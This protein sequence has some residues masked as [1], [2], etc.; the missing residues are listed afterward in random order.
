MSSED[1][2]A[3]VRRSEFAAYLGATGFTGAAFAMQQL[4]VSW[5]LIGVLQLPADR[6]GL[7]Q[8]AIGLPGIVLMLWGGASADR[9]D[10]RSLLL[11]AYGLA[12]L[13]PAFLGL[14]AATRGVEVWSVVFWGI[15]MSVAISFTTPAQQAILH[16]VS[17]SALQ[18]GV[19]ATTSLNFFVQTLGLAVAGQMERL[20][21]V[22]VLAVQSALLVV[23]ALLIQRVRAEVRTDGIRQRVAAWRQIG[24]GLR[25]TFGEPV[26][27]HVLILNFISSIFNAGAF[28]TVFPFIIKRIYDGDAALLATMMIVFYA[29]AMASNLA[30]LR[31]MP[32]AHPGRW[33]LLM[34]LSRIVIVFLLWIEPSWWLLV[35]AIVSWGLNMGVTSTLARAVVQES[36][37]AAYRG[38]I[39]SVYT[40]GLVGSPPIG[41]IVLGWIIEVFGTL[42]AL[43]PAM[44][45]SVV[46]FLYGVLIT[47]L[48]NYRSPE[49]DAVPTK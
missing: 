44:A 31:L 34:Q 7:L 41:A 15:G 10:P 38:R 47:G 2:S 4:L 1:A 3:A 9:I 5:L 46:L 33:Y 35:V 37:P 22:P 40:L 24:E 28:I 23:A 12:P 32:F 27:L 8:A 18:R 17:G 36:A 16:R 39:L 21:L 30:M 49:L 48:W 19:T 14:L 45:T 11:R 43:L 25:A 20:G 26:V 42:N 13:L 29:G 6:V